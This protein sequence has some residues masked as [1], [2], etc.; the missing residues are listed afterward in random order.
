MSHPPVP[1]RSL[2]SQFKAATMPDC[3]REAPY[4]VTGT[5]GSYI[6]HRSPCRFVP[7]QGDLYRGPCPIASASHLG[8]SRPK[9]HYQSGSHLFRALVALGTDERWDQGL[10]W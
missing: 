3:G 10:G 6:F 9:A 8:D 2:S 1:P 7:G 5:V 4:H